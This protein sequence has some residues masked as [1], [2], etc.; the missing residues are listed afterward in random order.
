VKFIGLAGVLAQGVAKKFANDS[1]FALYG[2][3]PQLASIEQ[4]KAEP[5]KYLRLLASEAARSIA[6][7]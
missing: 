1:T 5:A 2:I 3:V 7:V 6:S 4:S